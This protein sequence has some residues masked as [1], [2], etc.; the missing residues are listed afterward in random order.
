MFGKRYNCPRDT[1][2]GGR[3]LL[4]F[5]FLCKVFSELESDL[6]SIEEGSVDGIGVA[7]V[8]G[9]GWWREDG[10]FVVDIRPRA[11]GEILCCRFDR[12]R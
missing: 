3:S 5:S 1:E 8:A 11:L 9:G 2:P 7:S 12:S 10:E 4:A 6:A